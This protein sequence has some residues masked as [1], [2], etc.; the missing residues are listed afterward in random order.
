MQQLKE[1]AR[2]IRERQ[3]IHDRRAAGIPPPWTTNPILSK[4]RFC[5]VRREDDRVTCW[6]HDNWLRPH[7]DDLP[8]CIFAMAVA[9][10][11]N[12]PE[13]LE[14]IDWPVPWSAVRFAKRMAER[15]ASGAK[16]FTS[17]YMIHADAHFSGSKAAYLAEGVL[18]P[19]WKGR[20]QLA[21]F[22]TLRGLHEALMKYR[23]MGSFMAA[24]IVADVKWTPT[25]R[26]APD[27]VTFAAMGPGSER[28]MS[29]VEFGDSA[30]RYSS[31]NWRAALDELRRKLIPALPPELRDLD[32]QNIQN[33]LC[34]FSGYCKVKYLGGRKKELFKPS[35]EPY[36]QR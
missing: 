29:W 18:T 28:G 1:F 24:Q 17:A 16:I 21:A 20:G 35:K 12:W 3:A 8:S 27:W 7:E 19:I 33:C 9:R 30:T 11:V 10:L 4:Y 13:S 36:V 23:D 14:A 25:L 5:N 6:I 34:E 32:N 15:R 26:R 31:L 2:F 22:G